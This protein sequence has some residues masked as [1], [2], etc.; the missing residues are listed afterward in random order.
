MCT[1]GPESPPISSG[2]RRSL[3][4]SL[5]TS[6]AHPDNQRHAASRGEYPD[7]SNAHP[8]RRWDGE[9]NDEEEDNA[10]FPRVPQDAQVVSS[11][12]EPSSL[13]SDDDISSQSDMVQTCRRKRTHI[14][15]KVPTNSNGRHLTDPRKS[16]RTGL[17]WQQPRT[18]EE[19]SSTSKARTPSDSA[20]ATS[21][22][23]LPR[24]FWKR[25]FI[26]P[27]NI[28][29]YDVAKLYLQAEVYTGQPWPSAAVMENMIKRAWALA[30][31]KPKRAKEEYYS[32]GDLR[33]AEQAPSLLPDAVSLEMLKCRMSAC[34]GY[35]VSEARK[36]VVEW[37]KLLIADPVEC[38]TLVNNL[39]KDD[40]FLSQT[41]NLGDGPRT[42][43]FTVDDI[44]KLMRAYFLAN[45]G[46][47]GCKSYTQEYFSPLRWPIV[48]LVYTA[49]R[50]S[51]MD[52]EDTGQ[53]SLAV[54]DFSQVMF[55]DYYKNYYQ[56][57]QK[58]A[59]NPEEPGH[60]TAQNRRKH[61]EQNADRGG[62]GHRILLEHIEK[63]A[64]G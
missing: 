15:L 42:S 52:Y 39:L 6:Y 61:G 8:P 36:I 35:P 5:F 19:T 11:L 13:L 25:E 33:P 21:E 12:Y 60:K 29:V 38:R 34:R 3:H 59:Q 27:E 37:F 26:P 17:A 30:L 20:S 22:G 47:L 58:R 7:Y 28:L 62:A 9:S 55:G 46:S 51:L 23:K 2:P 24:K 48:L 41:V 50:C 63:N 43:W 10:Q 54:G 32:S 45:E 44:V 18:L 53:K 40:S 31:E 16:L 57:Y 4:T 56:T 14:N 64:R 49:L 1:N